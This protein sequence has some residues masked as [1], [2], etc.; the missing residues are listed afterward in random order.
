MFDGSEGGSHATWDYVHVR[1]DTGGDADAAVDA[2]V[3]PVLR[4]V[5]EALPRF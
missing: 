4:A 3:H 1:G 2:T 5:V